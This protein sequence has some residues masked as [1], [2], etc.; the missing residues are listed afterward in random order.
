MFLFADLGSVSREAVVEVR[1]AGVRLPCVSDKRIVRRLEWRCRG[2]FS[3][4]ASKESRSVSCLV[5]KLR[6]V[7]VGV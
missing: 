7:E 2:C 5:M 4:S 3:I 6:D 1:G